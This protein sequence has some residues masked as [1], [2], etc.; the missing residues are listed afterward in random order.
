MVPGK[1]G[2]RQC[3]TMFDIRSE[4]GAEA[5]ETK[6]PACGSTDVEMLPS[7]IP[8]GYSLELYFGSSG[9][10]YKC[11]KCGAEFELPAVCSISQEEQKKCTACGSIDIERLPTPEF[12]PPLYCS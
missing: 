6:C 1:Y 5:V 12:Q 10:K 3:K 8:N 4:T 9:W 11:H 2:C 7:W